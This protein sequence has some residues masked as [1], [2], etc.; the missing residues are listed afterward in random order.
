[1]L[2]DFLFLAMTFAEWTR[3]SRMDARSRSV[4]H[5]P[6][7]ICQ[8]LPWMDHVPWGKGKGK[9]V[10][11]KS[12]GWNQEEHKTEELSAEDECLAR[13]RDEGVLLVC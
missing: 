10:W 12:K 2:A 9:K 11:R 1:M 13:H 8:D 6:G 3:G 4:H 7:H 5:A